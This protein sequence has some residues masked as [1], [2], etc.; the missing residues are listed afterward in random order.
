MAYF[1]GTV[2]DEIIILYQ[3]QLNWT[4]LRTHYSKQLFKKRGLLVCMFFFLK[5]IACF[6]YLTLINYKGMYTFFS[7]CQNCTTSCKL[8]LDLPWGNLCLPCP[9]IDLCFHIYPP[10]IDRQGHW[11]IQ[12]ARSPFWSVTC[13]RKKKQAEMGRVVGAGD[14]LVERSL[15]GIGPIKQQCQTNT[16][17]EF[18][19]S[20]T[21]F[22]ALLCFSQGTSLYATLPAAHRNWD[23]FLLT[24]INILSQ[25]NEV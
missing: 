5:L 1:L 19:W 23:Y 7:I 10:S 9:T 14:E 24:I 17:K 15:G 16:T 13:R 4:W 20:F 11:V 25:V 18:V 2:F 22:D 8:R 3:E 6:A 21:N 12:S